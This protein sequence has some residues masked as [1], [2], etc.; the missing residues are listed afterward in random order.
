M[1]NTGTTSEPD[2]RAVCMDVVRVLEGFVIEKRSA[3]LDGSVPLRAAQGCKPFLDGNAA[4]FHLR[5]QDPAVI[6][7]GNEEGTLQLTD[8]A[9]GQITGD[10]SAKIQ[11]LAEQGILRRNGYWHKQLKKGFAWKKNSILFL[12]TGYLVRP[13]PGVWI[14][15][16]GAYN[17]RCLVDLIEYI[18]S[19]SESLTP[20]VLQL[21]LNSLRERVTWL[22]TELACLMPLRPN[23]R[24][25]ITSIEK[26]PRAGR[27][28]LDF[29]DPEYFNLREE[30]RYTGRYR[31]HTAGEVNLE[32]D[33]KAECRLILAGGPKL[34]RIGTFGRFA[35]S[36][37]FCRKHKTK[38]HLEFAEVRNICDVK[39]R[40]DGSRMRAVADMPDEAGRMRKDWSKLYGAEALPKIEYWLQYLIGISGP[41]REPF[42]GIAPW[43]LVATPPGWSSITDSFSIDGAD[44]MRGV[45]STDSF[46]GLDFVWQ[47]HKLGTFKM[48]RG[49]PLA[50]ILPVPRRLLESS[51]RELP[52]CGPTTHRRA[53]AD[54]AS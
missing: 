26:E 53:F 15:V 20:L 24:F 10:Y 49:V 30:G 12:W 2:P 11:Y 35:T 7:A 8:D 34:H 41:Y 50:R 44:G 25:S 27:A 28:Y 23:L 13:A 40:W 21:D 45:I 31:K 22:D 32:A 51:F 6:R 43:A 47:F 17:R 4:G 52:L 9:F 33:E 3:T 42:L 36:D 37:G 38:N 16:S 48:S 1:S 19:D 39:G 46:F 14:L 18:I 54:N 5:C 29:F